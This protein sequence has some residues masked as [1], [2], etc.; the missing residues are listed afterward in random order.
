MKKNR[1]ESI[2]R[3]IEQ[4]QT[5][6]KGVPDELEKRYQKLGIK[7]G[8]ATAYAQNLPPGEQSAQLR[9]SLAAAR[10]DPM[11]QTDADPSANPLKA[12]QLGRHSRR[13]I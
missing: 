13:M 8:Q 11:A 7:P 2:F 9:A 3:Q 12:P 4:L 5:D 10:V 1:F 6:L